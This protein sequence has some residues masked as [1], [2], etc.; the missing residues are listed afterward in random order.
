MLPAR[1]KLA[2]GEKRTR[3]ELAK[4]FRLYGESYRRT[5]PLPGSHGK[6][7]RAIEVCRTQELGGHLKQPGSSY[8]KPQ[9][10]QFRLLQLVFQ[11]N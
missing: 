2:A 8:H 10:A 4:I 3:P 1:P 6:V 9:G 5:H 11:A 7:M